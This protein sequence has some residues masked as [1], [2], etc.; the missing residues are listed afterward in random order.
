VNWLDF[1]ILAM[2]AMSIVGGLA[3]GFARTAVGLGA[4][5]VG[6][7]CGLWFYGLAGQ[8]FQPYVSSRGVASFL[9]FFVIFIGV[10]LAGALLG[11]LLAKIFDIAGLSWLDRL[12]GG[13]FG[14]ARGALTCIVLV[15]LMLAFDPHP[16]TTSVVNSRFAPYVAGASEWLAAVTPYELKV[17]FAKSYDRVKELWREAVKKNQPERL[18]AERI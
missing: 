5:L 7:L 4:T 12:L 8:Y 18:P 2:V 9:G 13:A 6:L 3:K 16:P 17:G 15:M 11:A 14:V 10:T 1:V